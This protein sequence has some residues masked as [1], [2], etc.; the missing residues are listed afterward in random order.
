M[1][2]PGVANGQLVKENSPIARR[3]NNL[4][5][6]EQHSVDVAWDIL[7]SD[8]FADLQACIFPDGEEKIDDDTIKE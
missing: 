3:Y 5:V 1:E 7:M 6:A 4:S 2:H 8:S